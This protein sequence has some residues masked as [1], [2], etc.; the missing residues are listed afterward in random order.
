MTDTSDDELPTSIRRV[1]SPGT[2]RLVRLVESYEDMQT[3]LACCERLITVLGERGAVTD[4]VGVEALWTLAVLSY[5][6]CFSG[7]GDTAALSEADLSDSPAEGT[8]EGGA[9]HWHRV[10]VHLRDQLSSVDANPREVYSVGVAQDAEGAVNAVAVTS[11]RAPIVDAAAVR[12]AGSLALPLCGVLD[13]RISDAQKDI[14]E[15]VRSVPRPELEAMELI[16]VAA[17]G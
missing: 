11:I 15:Q 17:T 16:E 1:E 14:L 5:A 6:R 9:L 10:L 12:Q 4:D 8:A 3:V 13:A 2:G 7:T